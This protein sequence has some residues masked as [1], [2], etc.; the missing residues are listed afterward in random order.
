MSALVS[1][2]D[3]LAEHAHKGQKRRYT[4]DDY[5][6]HPRSVAHI[7]KMYGVDDDLTIAG[8]LLHDTL[9]DTSLT[10]ELLTHYMGRKVCDLVVELTN[11]TTPADGDRKV[12]SAIER[13]RLSK[14]SVRAKAIKLA[15]ISH[16]A[17]S[18]IQ[19][20]PKFAKVYVPEKLATLEVLNVDDSLMEHAR[21]TL[22][23]Y[24]G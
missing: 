21:N 11:I 4:G 13:E 15:D 22:L 17:H 10:R 24:H 18:V 3:W 12:R 1:A 19:F 20:D 5:I 7:L 9:E 16:N 2:A 8:A 23:S 6:V 14:V